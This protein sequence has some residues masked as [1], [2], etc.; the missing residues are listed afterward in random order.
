MA[1]R[2]PNRDQ[3]PKSDRAAPTTEE[4]RT[5][6]DSGRTGEKVRDFD[7][8]AAPLGTDDEAAGLPPGARR[9]NMSA[10]PPADHVPANDTGPKKPKRSM[11]IAFAALVGLIV[12]AAIVAALI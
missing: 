9:R 1:D 12:L 4:I 10:R 2:D 3:N 6:I 11:L 8:A 7:P 5:A